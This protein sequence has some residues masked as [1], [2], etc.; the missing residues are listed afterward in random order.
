MENTFYL[1]II[2]LDRQFY[3]G[4]G[5][6][7]IL[8]IQDGLYGVLPRHE[9][10]VA[11]I[12]PGE[13]KF[14]VDGQWRVATVSDGF[15]EITPDYVVVLVASAERPEEIDVKRA[16]AAKERAQER[17]RYKQSV[18]EYYNSKAALARAMARLK[19]RGV[20]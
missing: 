13:L 4:P 8:P 14:K 9:T 15:A 11:A 20:K 18:I 17:L 3:T 5:E 16:E 1:E 7:V 19:A 6:A 12:V 2:T 10:T